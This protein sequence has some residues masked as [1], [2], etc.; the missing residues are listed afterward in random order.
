[1]SFTQ[2][3]FYIDNV[4]EYVESW[5]HLGNILNVNQSDAACIL[6]RRNIMVGQIN[7]VICYFG[8]L[9][10]IAKTELLH[11]YCSSLYAWFRTVGS[12]TARVRSYMYSLADG[13]QKTG[14]LPFNTHRDIV[15]V[16]KWPTAH[17]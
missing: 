15:S 7:D 5:P 4:I 3:L 1:M 13:A 14:R 12:T 11:T 9:D 6:N 16:L 10:P 8:K 2:P 17:V